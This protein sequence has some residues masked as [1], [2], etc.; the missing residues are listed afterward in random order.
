MLSAAKLEIDI[1]NNTVLFHGD[2]GSTGSKLIYGVVR[3]ILKSD[4]KIKSLVLKMS[5]V[6]NFGPVSSPGMALGFSLDE[7]VEM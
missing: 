5:G 6:V 7:I 1:Q 2:E 3:I 4:K